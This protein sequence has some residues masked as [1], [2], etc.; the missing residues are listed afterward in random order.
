MGIGGAEKL[1]VEAAVGVQEAGHSVTIYTAYHNPHPKLSFPATHDGSLDVRVHGNWLPYQAVGKFQLVKALLRFTWLS[2]VVL[3]EHKKNPYDVIF[4]DQISATL[5]IIKF[6]SGV[7]VVFYCHFPDQ[8]LTRRDSFI[9]KMYRIPFDLL[10]EFTT[11]SAHEILVNSKFT[12]SVFKKTFKFLSRN[13]SILYP[14]VELKIKNQ[15]EKDFSKGKPIQFLSLNRYERKKNIQL[16]LEA[17]ALLKDTQQWKN[18]HLSL[19][20]AGGYSDK[21][22]ENVEHLKELMDRA[23]QLGIQD[24]VTFMTSL[25]NEVRDK[26]IQEAVC[27]LYTP[28]NEHFGIVPLEAGLLSTAVIACNSGGPLETVEDG[29]TGYLVEPIPENWSRVMKKAVED[30]KH[31][32]EMGKAGRKRVNTHFS[33]KQFVA[34]LVEALKP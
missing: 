3:Y 19:V 20:I 24:K 21:V 15:I 34:R 1:I 14:A 6:F 22:Q 10:E 27:L 30:P 28:S 32:V 5:P 4:V 8:L 12:A 18:N 26:V 2:F 7:K 13:P 25:E 29:K 17:F 31:F 9:K 11:N 23:A 33:R 16:A